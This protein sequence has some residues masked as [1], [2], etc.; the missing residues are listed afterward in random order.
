MHQDKQVT[1]E[2]TKPRCPTLGVIS[3]FMLVGGTVTAYALMASSGGWSD[4]NKEVLG[5]FIGLGA[6]VISPFLAFC[7][8]AGE[9]PKAFGV[10][11]LVTEAV[12]ITWFIAN[13]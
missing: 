7:S 3:L 8:L 10:M 13:V 1:T 12:I 5:M 11:T 4:V 6:W 2:D 9:S